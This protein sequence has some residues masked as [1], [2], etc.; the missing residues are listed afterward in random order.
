MGSDLVG[1]EEPTEKELE[2]DQEADEQAH[3]S[4]QQFGHVH[5]WKSDILIYLR[6]LVIS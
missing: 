5:L 6:P 3:R 1:V 2:S 4:S